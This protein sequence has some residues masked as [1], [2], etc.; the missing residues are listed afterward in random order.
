MQLR[1]VQEVQEKSEESTVLTIDEHGIVRP[2]KYLRCKTYTKNHVFTSLI[3][4][5]LHEKLIRA[6]VSYPIHCQLLA[7]GENSR[8]HKEQQS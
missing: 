5:S 7:I 6:G 2:R 3:I 4:N 1:A 8:Y